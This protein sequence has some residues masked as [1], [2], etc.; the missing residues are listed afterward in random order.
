M[1]EECREKIPEGE[2]RCIDLSDGAVD[3]LDMIRQSY[4]SNKSSGLVISCY[5]VPASL[6]ILEPVLTRILREFRN[7]RIITV[8]YNMEGWCGRKTER[9]LGLEAHVYDEESLHG[10]RGGEEV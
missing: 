1:I 5:F 4:L 8:E 3:W 2:F 7:T 9:V 6:A 10:G